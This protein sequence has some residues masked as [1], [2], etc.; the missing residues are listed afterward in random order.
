MLAI[1][2]KNLKKE[3]IMHLLKKAGISLALSL[4]LFSVAHADATMTI[5][6]TGTDQY[7][8]QNPGNFEI[9]RVTFEYG[10]QSITALHTS[11]TLVDQ[12]WGYQD[13]GN[14]VFVQLLSNNNT[15]Y[16]LNVAGASHDW[17]TLTFDLAGNPGVYSALNGALANINRADGPIALRFVTDAWGYPGWELHTRDDSLSVSTSLQPVPEPETYAMFL[18]GLGAIGLLKRRGDKAP[19]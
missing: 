1:P 6:S 13:P 19:A 17:Q 15:V 3:T 4:S 11:V 8:N 9:G 14:G 16:T 10:T 5:G 12:G 18:L 7:W 2:Q